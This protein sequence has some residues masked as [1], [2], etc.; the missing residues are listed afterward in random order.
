MTWVGDACSNYQLTL[1]DTGVGDACSNYQ[2]TLCDTGVGD[3]CS[4]YQLT[5]CD[6]GVGD[7]CSNYQLTLCDTGVGD[8]CSNY[9]LTL[10]DTGVGD[11]WSNYQLTLCDTGVGDAWSNYQLTLCD[12]GVG[13]ACSNYHVMFQF[14]CF[15][16]VGNC[17]HFSNHYSKKKLMMQMFTRV[18]CNPS[19]NG[20][21]AGKL[22]RGDLDNCIIPC[23]PR[24]C[25]ELI[26]RTGKSRT[27]IDVLSFVIK[28][29]SCVEYWPTLLRSQTCVDENKELFIKLFVCYCV[30]ILLQW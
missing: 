27:S 23:T 2:L 7:A 15:R 5:Q 4:N 6:T 22:C 3:A 16:D 12:T 9:Q 19:L 10:C 8:A 29:L 20:D 24:G 26:Q 13:D 18:T 28:I 11:A 21:N 17:L 14:V 1:C 25:L 30:N